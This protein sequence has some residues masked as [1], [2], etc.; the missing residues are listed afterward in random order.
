MEPITLT[1]VGVAAAVGSAVTGSFSSMLNYVFKKNALDVSSNRKESEA[2]NDLLRALMEKVDQLEKYRLEEQ[3]RR[4]GE[5]ELAQNEKLAKNSEIADLHNFHAKNEYRIR[6]LEEHSIAYVQK[7]ADQDIINA[8]LKKKV[9]EL[10]ETVR[11]L[12]DRNRTLEIEVT[13]YR[14]AHPSIPLIAFDPPLSQ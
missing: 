14:E 4:F 2:K 8:D 9:S 7:I 13:K 12:S 3:D 10:T 5:R 1:T 11:T 6:E